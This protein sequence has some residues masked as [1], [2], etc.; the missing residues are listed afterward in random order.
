VHWHLQTTRQSWTSAELRLRYLDSE[1]T[2]GEQT[3]Q[4]YFS[5][6]G[7]APF[8]GLPSISNPLNN[9]ISTT[10]TQPGYYFV[11]SAP[12]LIFADDFE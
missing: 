5:S 3:L 1:L 11:G 10:I 7:S 4:V 6:T 2:S 12:D 8:T 9:T